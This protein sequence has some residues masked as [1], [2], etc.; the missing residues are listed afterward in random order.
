MSMHG[1][2]M[3]DEL[4]QLMKTE[5]VGALTIVVGDSGLI[6]KFRVL[7]IDATLETLVLHEIAVQGST[8]V[9]KHRIKNADTIVFS[10]SLE[11]SV[12][13]LAI[14]AGAS[15]ALRVPIIAG[16]LRLLVSLKNLSEHFLDAAA[17]FGA[18]ETEFRWLPTGLL[19]GNEST[20]TAIL[21]IRAPLAIAIAT[22]VATVTSIASIAAVAG[23]GIR[24]GGICLGGDPSGL[25]GSNLRIVGIRSDAR[26]IGKA[27]S[28]GHPVLHLLLEDVSN[29]NGLCQTPVVSKLGSLTVLH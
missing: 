11:D 3:F 28:N 17:R 9:L 22:A 8:F 13:K 2:L 7:A 25:G 26:D 6:P 21:S 16:E 15:E 18:K 27:T 29:T 24:V 10:H 19:G 4:M 5:A 12:S 1:M 20:S 23:C 14:F